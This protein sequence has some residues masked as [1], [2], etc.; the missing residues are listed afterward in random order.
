MFTLEQVKQ[1]H[2]QV[3]SGAEFPAYIREL[4]KLGV[5]FYETFVPDGSTTFHGA[6]HFML[7]SGPRYDMLAIAE[8]IDLQQFKQDLLRHQKGGS[9][10]PEACRQFAASGVYKWEVCTDKMTC[11]YFDLQ[12]NELLVEQIPQ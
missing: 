2:A 8:K 10:Y 6:D 3:K 12:G 4:K 7:P 9:T 11:T 1:A 5:T